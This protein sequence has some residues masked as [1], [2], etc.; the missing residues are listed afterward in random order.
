MVMDLILAIDQGTTNTKAILLTGTGHIVALASRPMQVSYPKPGWAEQSASAIWSTVTDVIA[1]IVK[2][3]DGHDIAALAIS[4]QRESIVLWDASTGEPVAPCVI[5]QCRR[6]SERCAA[7]REA[8]HEADIVARTGLSLDPLFPATK[9]AWLLDNLPG[10]RESAGNGKLRAG[11][12]D[13]WLIWKLTGGKS[14]ATDHSNA[15]RTQLFNL[16]TSSWDP[17]LCALF[18]VPPQ[19]LPRVLSSDAS[20]GCTATSATVLPEGIPIRAVMGDSHAATFGHGIGGPGN[21]KV[22]LGTGSSLMAVT[23]PRRDSRHGLSSTIAWSRDGK[24]LYALEGNI[25]VSGHAAAFA[26]RLLGLK[27][28]QELSEL[29]RT[30]DGSD[31]ASFVPALAG[32]GA[33]HWHDRARGLICGMSL[34]TTPAHVARAVLEAIALQIVDVLHAME[35][36][37]GSDFPCLCVDGGA[38]RNDFL[39]QLLSDL[40]DRPVARGKN[41][42][43]SVLGVGRM[44][45][46]ALNLWHGVEEAAVEKFEPKMPPQQ[47]RQLQMQWRSALDRAMLEDR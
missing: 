16:N 12:V 3:A 15:S 47:R 37:L 40:S 10:A 32:L 21:V 39:M 46:E 7:L 26:R 34:S 11:T 29:A 43:V 14:H 18:D 8:D 28:E 44:A 41:T 38:S 1:D 35:S 9:L 5:W 23:G 20:F 17:S 25:A 24:I 31:G 4:N 36:D 2:S 19:L 42:E 13:S 45:A 22:T 30:V 27:D 6:S 33:P